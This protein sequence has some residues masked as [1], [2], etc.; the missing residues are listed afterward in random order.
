MHGDQTGVI[1]SHAT[2]YG[3][4]YAPG[5]FNW[6]DAPA[7][8]P[9]NVTANG[10]TISLS[11]TGELAVLGAASALSQIGTIHIGYTDGSSSD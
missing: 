7:G 10:Q 3:T 5:P 6:P 8:T 4:N 9:D 2:V 1:V 11:G